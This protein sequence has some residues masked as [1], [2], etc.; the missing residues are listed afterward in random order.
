[1][2]VID[3]DDEPGAHAAPIT[4]VAWRPDGERLATCSYDGTVRIWDTTAPAGPVPVE[5]LR[6]RRLVNGVAWHPT[7]PDVLATASADKTVGIWRLGTGPVTVL[8][9]HTDDVNAVAWLPDGERLAC[10]SEDGRATLW[11]AGTGA[12]LAEIGGHTA[13]CMMVSAA[14]DG[15]IATVGEDGL[16]AVT[17]PDSPRAPVTR[18]YDVSVEGCAWSH[19]GT[20][21]AVARDDGLVDLLGPDLDVLLSVRACGAA[22][23]TVAWSDDDT[24]FIA[25]GYDGALHVFDTAGIRLRTIRDQRVWPRSVSAARGRLAVGGFGGTPYVYDLASG[26][27]LSTP[28]VRTHGPNAMAAAGS[29]LTIGCDSGVLLTVD[30]DEPAEARAV[31]LGDSPILSLAAGDDVVYAGTYCGEVL[32]WPPVGSARLGSPVPSLA[33]TGEGLIA[34]TYGGDLIALDLGLTVTGRGTPHDGSVKSLAATPGG[35]VS[36]STDRRVAIGG[37]GDR[38]TL[39]EHG[40]LVN[41]V[42]CLGGTV[43]ASASRDHTVKVGRAGGGARLTLLGP[44]ESVKCVALLGDPAAPTVL[45]GSYDFGLYAW[46]V[47]WDD[48]GATLRSGRL[49]AEFRQ[50]VSC[51]AAIDGNRVAVAGWDGRIL[52]VASTPDGPVVTHDLAVRDLLAGARTAVPA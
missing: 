14:P 22:A 39:W 31:R 11:H 21:L 35:F 46:T 23:R 29:R 48:P 16:V 7:D 2:R 28:D 38:R 19:S 1:M 8:A 49:L 17:D 9:R 24:R 13:H 4:G 26:A 34:G 44:D 50:G 43:I 10:V 37:L 15:R 5:T 30:L 33:L 51:A 25:G 47:D 18:R 42:A 45:A 32:S 36:A 27:T 3:L 52:V 12:L 40:N 6:H 20:T 41:A